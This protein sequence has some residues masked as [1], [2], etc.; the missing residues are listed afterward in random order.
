M[1]RAGDGRKEFTLKHTIN[2]TIKRYRDTCGKQLLPTHQKNI[3]SSSLTQ[4]DIPQQKKH[5]LPIF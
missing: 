3:L 4:N 5:T 1:M 2:L